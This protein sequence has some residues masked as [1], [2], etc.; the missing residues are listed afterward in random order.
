MSILP[1]AFYF[2]LSNAKKNV[3][4]LNFSPLK[5]NKCKF[6][7]LSRDFNVFKIWKKT[8]RTFNKTNVSSC[9][10]WDVYCSVIATIRLEL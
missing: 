1:N 8:R 9:Y 4:M 6:C 2:S 7:Y 10:S 3:L 5:T